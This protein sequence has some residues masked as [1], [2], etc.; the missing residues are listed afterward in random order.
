MSTEYSMDLPPP[1]R[2]GAGRSGNLLWLLV[3]IVALCLGVAGGI[4][5]GKKVGSNKT[6]AAAISTIP[7]EVEKG[8]AEARIAVA[9]GRWA[10]ARRIYQG[11]LE[12]DPENAEANTSL[13]LV[14]SHLQMPTEIWSLPVIL[15]G[16]K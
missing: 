3:T 10:T 1:R 12:K 14:E 5:L 13:P 2:P 15:P 16:R 9:E 4:W 7:R 6:P 11:V 8:L